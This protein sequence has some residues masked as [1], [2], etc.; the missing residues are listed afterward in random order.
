MA[1]IMKT[2]TLTIFLIVTAG[3]LYS[4]NNQSTTDSLIKEYSAKTHE[5]YSDIYKCYQDVYDSSVLNDRSKK[6]L[7]NHSNTDLQSLDD[8]V[9]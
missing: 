7:Y 1:K 4:Q 5:S 8:N 9:Y 2:I 3:Y 6:E